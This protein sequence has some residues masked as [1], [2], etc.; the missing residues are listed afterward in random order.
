MRNI[1]LCPVELSGLIQDYENQVEVAMPTPITERV[2]AIKWFHRIDLGNGIITQAER[3]TFA[4]IAALHI[5]QNLTGK[6]V[7]DVGAWDGAFAF[8]CERRGARSVL[9]T[10]HWA[11]QNGGDAGFELA[12]DILQSRVERQTICV[13]DLSPET[14][15]TFDLVLFLGVL[16]HAQD[17]M[18]YL[19]NIFSVCRELAIVETHIDAQD[20][21]RPAAVYYPG[22]TLAGD[23]TNF[24]GPN[25]ACVVAMLKDV[26]F[27]RVEQFPAWM[28]GTVQARIEFHA[29][30]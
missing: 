17:P 5:P 24:W 25:P 20:Y 2:S 11:W 1:G 15:G 23:P 28:P 30:R 18:R 27:S 16:Y 12:R 6:T 10:D 9:A 29:F 4:K 22:D 19:R 14:V 21:P 3:D 13:E 8:E 26:G 7:L